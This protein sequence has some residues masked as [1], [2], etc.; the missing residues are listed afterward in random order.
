MTIW[1]LRW[2]MRRWNKFTVAHLSSYIKKTGM[3]DC[4][5]S[6]CCRLFSWWQSD[7]FSSYCF[8]PFVLEDKDKPVKFLLNASLLLWRA[9]MLVWSECQQMV[10]PWR[11]HINHSILSLTNCA[12]FFETYSLLQLH[13]LWR[14]CTQ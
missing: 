7:L 8:L 1:F 2:K 14:W 13:R 6:I 4:L 9:A 12:S 11:C 5:G 3:Q 10:C